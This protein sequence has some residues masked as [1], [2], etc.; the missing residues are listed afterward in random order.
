MKIWVL[1]HVKKGFIQ[2]PEIFYDANR[3]NRRKHKLSEDLNPD[4]DELAIFE[5]EIAVASAQQA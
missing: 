1:T 2:E 4:Y 5:K 3:A